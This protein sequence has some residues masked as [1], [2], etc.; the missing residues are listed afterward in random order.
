[1]GKKVSGQ[2]IY[3]VSGNTYLTMN[4]ILKKRKSFHSYK[5]REIQTTAHNFASVD[6][7][8]DVKLVELQ[9]DW[10]GEIEIR[11]SENLLGTL[12]RKNGLESTSKAN[13]IY[14][15][16]S[17]RFK[18]SNTPRKIGIRSGNQATFGRDEDSLM[19]EDWIND[20][21]LII[22]KNPPKEASQYVENT[23]ES[24]SA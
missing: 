4:S 19:I 17:V 21:Q 10:G 13:I 11:K 2:N 9:Y 18:G 6:G 15:K 16:F 5:L 24:A 7:I 23:G 8:E 20:Q 1:M 22:P 3:A 12:I 14:A